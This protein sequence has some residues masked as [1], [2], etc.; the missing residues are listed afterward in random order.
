MAGGSV[1]PP[2]TGVTASAHP[3][4]RF[5]KVALCHGDVLV[6]AAVDLGCAHERSSMETMIAC[7]RKCPRVATLSG[8]CS[9]KTW[10]VRCPSARSTLSNAP[11]SRFRSSMS[12]WAA[13]RKAT[14]VA[15]GFQLLR[16]DLRFQ[17]LLHRLQDGLGLLLARVSCCSSLLLAG[18]SCGSRST[19]SGTA[20]ESASYDA[21]INR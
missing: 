12:A 14:Y 21:V 18:Q 2:A 3:A 19:K 16:P 6:Q 7:I 4:P 1:V 20:R 9:R 5:L 10:Y 8:P 13:C 15:L 11:R 17:G